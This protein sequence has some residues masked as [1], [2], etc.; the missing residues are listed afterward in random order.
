YWE[1][2][3]AT[4]VGDAVIVRTHRRRRSSSVIEARVSIRRR[5]CGGFDEV[6]DEIAQRPYDDVG[7]EDALAR[8]GFTVLDCE[9]YDPFESAGGP[10]KALWTCASP[11]RARPGLR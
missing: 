11:S 8:T 5:T 2:E 4:D 9:R 6:T 3:H 10:T 7:G 1:G